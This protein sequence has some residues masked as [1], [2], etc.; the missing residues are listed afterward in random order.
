MQ[1]FTGS[2]RGGREVN[3]AEWKLHTASPLVRAAVSGLFA[4][5]GI[6]L[7]LAT[8]RVGSVEGSSQVPKV[9]NSRRQVG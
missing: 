2:A 5:W 3:V 1:L 6:W 9:V 4:R 7:S 8:D